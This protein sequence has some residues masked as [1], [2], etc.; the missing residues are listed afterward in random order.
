MIVYLLT[1]SSCRSFIRG[2]I[3]NQKTQPIPC[4]QY[5]ILVD[6]SKEDQTEISCVGAL[7]LNDLGELMISFLT[8]NYLYLNRYVESGFQVSQDVD[9]S[10]MIEICQVGGEGGSMTIWKNTKP[11]QP[12]WWTFSSAIVG[13]D[14][15][16]N[17]MIIYPELGEL[18]NYL[19]RN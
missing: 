10:V 1:G 11:D 3:M 16:P 9:H 13:R 14:I 5:A 2:N 18:L 17:P 7:L 8:E 12:V 15:G 6:Y 4:G 19:L